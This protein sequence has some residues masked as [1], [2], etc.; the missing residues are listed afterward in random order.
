MIQKS[1]KNKIK[2]KKRETNFTINTHSFNREA[3]CIV[4]LNHTHIDSSINKSITHNFL[5]KPPPNEI[6]KTPKKLRLTKAKSEKR[7]TKAA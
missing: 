5:Q 4:S 2:V 1:K 6:N 3:S 7:H